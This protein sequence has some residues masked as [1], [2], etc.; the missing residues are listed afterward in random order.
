MD[1]IGAW[2]A[3]D[4]S[5]PA[6]SAIPLVL[7]SGKVTHAFVVAEGCEVEQEGRD[8]VFM[9]C[10]ERCAQQLRAARELDSNLLGPLFEQID[11]LYSP[12]LRVSPSIT[13]W[14]CDVR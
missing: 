6:G 1:G 8:L 14:Q 11:A 7:P 9:T 3:V 12:E 2:R 5:H 10:E 4:V 13:R